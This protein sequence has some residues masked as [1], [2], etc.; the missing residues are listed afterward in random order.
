MINF[1]INIWIFSEKITLKIFGRLVSNL[2]V[3]KINNAWFY[4]KF[5]SDK[6]SHQ[7]PFKFPPT[8]NGQDQSHRDQWQRTHCAPPSLFLVNAGKTP[9][10]GG[11]NGHPFSL[12]W[13]HDMISGPPS[14]NHD[15][16]TIP[17]Q[18]PPSVLNCQLILPCTFHV[19]FTSFISMAPPHPPPHLSVSLWPLSYCRVVICY[20]APVPLAINSY[21]PIVKLK[22]L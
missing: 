4:Y 8:F 22:F 18:N 12:T 14:Q 6:M 2:S 11:F 10:K 13:Q 5:G 17:P 20:I 7:A 3:Q 1:I 16:L 9:W 21:T 15:P 19:C